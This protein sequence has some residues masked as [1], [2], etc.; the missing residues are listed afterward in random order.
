MTHTCQP[1]ASEASA[2]GALPLLLAR[3]G[4]PRLLG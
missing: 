2:V 1:E 3:G 4:L